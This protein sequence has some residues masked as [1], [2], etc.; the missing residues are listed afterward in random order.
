MLFRS[1]FLAQGQTPPDIIHRL[2]GE[3]GKI[4]RVPEVNEQLTGLGAEISGA[5]PQ[6]YG[7]MIRAELA[8]WPKVV[9]A[10]KIKAD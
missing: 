5:G 7:A 1:G 9:A 3:I 8:K 10:A 2:N 6:E 4:L